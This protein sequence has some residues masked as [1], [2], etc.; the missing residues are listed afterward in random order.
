MYFSFLRLLLL[1]YCANYFY[2]CYMV[3]SR[4]DDLI[5]TSLGYS[6]KLTGVLGLKKYHQQSGPSPIDAKPQ[7]N[8]SSWSFAVLFCLIHHETTHYI[9]NG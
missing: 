2:Y 4:Q 5:E 6:E 7:G 3:C 9:D 8:W 1:Y